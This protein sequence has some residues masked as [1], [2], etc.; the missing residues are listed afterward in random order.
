MLRFI[1]IVLYPMK[2]RL[3][4]LIVLLC[5]GKLVYAQNDYREGF[6]INSS[7]DTLYGKIDYRG[8]YKMSTLCRFKDKNNQINE[9]TPDDIY[10]FRF[11]GG[12]Y[13]VSKPI[14]DEKFFLEY[15]I[16]G[17]VNIYY[18]RDDRGM[19][20]TNDHYYIEKEGMDMVELPYSEEIKEVDGRE[21]ISKSNK[22]IGILNYYMQD[23]SQFQSRI[24]SISKPSHEGLLN[25]AEDYHYAVCEGEKCIIYEKKLPF[26]KFNIEGLVGT[27]NI[28]NIN[29]REIVG[30]NY[31]KTGLMVHFWMPRVNEKLYFKTGLLYSNLEQRVSNDDTFGY[32]APETRTKKYI[33]PITHIAYLLPSTYRL[34]PSVSVAIL[35]PTYSAGLQIKIHKKVNLG[36]QGWAFF[37]YNNVVWVPNSLSAYSILGNLYIDL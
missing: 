18:N 5:C 29:K 2:I 12:K 31:F 10:G 34:R 37:D 24:Q 9:Y 13:Y 16:K 21:V 17:K 33:I 23:A 19:Y 27:T 30:N 7:L 6:I 25:L 14:G 4:F 35:S 11:I 1:N 22:H 3:L 26:F 20:S 32:K 36:I 28:Q 8:D 15:L